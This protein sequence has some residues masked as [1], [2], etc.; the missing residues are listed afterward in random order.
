MRKKLL[1]Y[2]PILLL[3]FS[4]ATLASTL[5]NYESPLN[6]ELGITD[7]TGSYG[8]QFD[9]VNTDSS[10]IWHFFV[11]TEETV[12]NGIGSFPSGL[13]TNLHLDT[14]FPEYDA[15][16]LNSA[17]LYEHNMWY[18]PFATTGL[19]IGSSASLYFEMTSLY[20]SFLYGYETLDSGYSQNNGTGYIAAVGTAPI[21]EP[22]SLLLLGTG[23][24]VL[25]L[26]VYRRK[27]K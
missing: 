25:G 21:P 4:S 5:Y 3:V 24:G 7:L 15:R 13:A 19:A 11:W 20:N 8:Y 14:V 27:R 17:L 16:N 26:T 12:S 22:T 18:S 10:E 2:L 1:V 9:F 6:V 23:L